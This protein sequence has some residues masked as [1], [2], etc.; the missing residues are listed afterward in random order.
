MNRKE[1]PS[2]VSRDQFMVIE[3]LFLG[4]KKKTCPRRVDLYDVFCGILYVLKNAATWKGIPGDFP[5]P[6]TVR[7]YF[8][9]W[10]RVLPGE[11]T[12]V[13][14]RALKK[15]SGSATQKEWQGKR[16]DVLHS[17]RA[18]REEHGHSTA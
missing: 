10:S 18:K 6:S 7:Y 16:D 12:S 5:K 11:E 8:D 9:Q 2:D 4:A 17:G 3:E 1:Y 15:C 14:D 13:L